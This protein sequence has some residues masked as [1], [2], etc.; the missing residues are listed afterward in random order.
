[1]YLSL[2][3]ALHRFVF[4]I[5]SIDSGICLQGSDEIITMI[6]GFCQHGYMTRMK[7]VKGT[8]CNADPFSVGLEIFYFIEYHG[9]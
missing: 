5:W 6:L 7:K 2:Y 9:L 3:D 4:G 1:L 8:E